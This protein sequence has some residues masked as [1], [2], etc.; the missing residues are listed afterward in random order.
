MDTE[1]GYPQTLVEAVP[2]FSDQDTALRFVANLRWPNGVECPR[3]GAKD[4]RFLP[5]RRIWECH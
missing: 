3:C 2:Y 5:T 1:Q 4:V